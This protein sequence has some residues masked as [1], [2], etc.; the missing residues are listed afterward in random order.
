[1]RLALDY[2]FS[3]RFSLGGQYLGNFGEPNSFGAS[4][5][6]IGRPD[7][8]FDSTQDGLR[9][10]TS[11]TSNLH[12]RWAL[13][14][15]GLT[16]SFDLD[17]FDYDNELDQTNVIRTLGPEG[18]LRGTNLAQQNRSA[19]R[20]DNRSARVD[21]E[22][23]LGTVK[24][25]YG[26]ALNYTETFG[27]QRSFNVGTGPATFDSLLSNEFLY[28]ENIQ[29]AY[30]NASGSFGEKWNWQA[31]LRG[32]NTQT[33]SY[34]VTLDQRTPNDYFRLFP[35][36]FL[37]HRP[38]DD[39][40][41]SFSYGRRINRPGFRNLNPFRL[42]INS[43]SYSEGNPFLQPSFTDRF[44][45]THGYKGWL[46]SNLFFN[47]TLDGHGTL[48]SQDPETQVQAVLR[49]NYFVDYYFGIGESSTRE[50]GR[51]R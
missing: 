25:D 31:G 29:A 2:E 13:D 1:G 20:I 17:L 5:T 30:L 26:F 22:H 43:N 19:Q 16:L 37:S 23:P 46:R 10:V 7:S 48:F 14:T 8:L 39:H 4:R 15:N 3:P 45:F 24:L 42:Y 35:T 47:R 51:D 18:D 49:R 34:S 36:L 50:A 40:D 12:G 32:E 38:N 44:E 33:E 28:E 41:F 11:H 6:L 21:V 27:D 9:E